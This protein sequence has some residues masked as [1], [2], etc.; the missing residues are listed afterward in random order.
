MYFQSYVLSEEQVICGACS[1]HV[2]VTS[3]LS[4]HT[5]DLAATKSTKFQKSSSQERKVT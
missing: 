2:G 4:Q 1:F 3:M 5:N